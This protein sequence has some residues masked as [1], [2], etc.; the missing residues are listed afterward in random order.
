MLIH[1]E[2]SGL[3]FIFQNIFGGMVKIATQ[4]QLHKNKLL[5][6][7]ATILVSDYFKIAQESPRI[8]FSV[9]QLRER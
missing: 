7:T 8:L 3:C 1:A 2:V 4:K 9:I 5:H 6:R